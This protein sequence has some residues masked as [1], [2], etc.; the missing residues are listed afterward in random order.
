MYN[1][2]TKVTDYMSIVTTHECNKTCPFCVDKYRGHMEYITIQNVV[3]ALD[4]AKKQSIKDIL[5]IGGEPTL[6]P[7]IITISKLVKD[8][9][10]NLILTTNYTKPSIVKKLDRYVD[11]FNISWYNQ[12]ELPKQ[13]DFTADLTL[14]T[15]IF[16]GQLDTKEKLD[17]F[18]DKY[19]KDFILKFSTLTVCNLFTKERQAVAYLDNLTTDSFILFNEIQGQRYRNCIIKRYDKIINKNANQSFKCHADGKITTSWDRE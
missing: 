7:E 1:I 16:K 2:K 9:G 13:K 10:F 14:S 5:L 15:L 4:F 17:A 19:Q 18:I 12:K 3:K 11:S 6:H 8:Y